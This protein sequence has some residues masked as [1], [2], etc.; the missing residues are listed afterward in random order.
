MEGKE[1]P[2]EKAKIE[3]AYENGKW[4]PVV[5]TKLD[6]LYSQGILDIYTLFTSEL[7]LFELQTLPYEEAGMVLDTIDN[8]PSEEDMSKWIMKEC[9]Q[10]RKKF[11]TPKEKEQHDQAKT[12]FLTK[13]LLRAQKKGVKVVA[14]SKRE[15][16]R[17]SMGAARKGAGAPSGGAAR[18]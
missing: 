18:D 7:A 9:E 14:S 10:M 1:L 16:E 6:E 17:L 12:V 5:K 13:F 3:L 15:K 2:F 4:H 11:A 8:K